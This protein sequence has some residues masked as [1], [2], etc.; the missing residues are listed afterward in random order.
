MGQLSVLEGTQW[1][2]V[3]LLALIPT[4]C[5]NLTFVWAVQRI[6]ST[7][8]AIMGALEPLTAVIVGALALGEELS[9]GQELGI[10]IVL[11]AVLLLVLSPF[12]SH[13]LKRVWSLIVDR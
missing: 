2:Y 6:G 13:C 11:I 4:V 9:A 7:P 12:I 3:F 10:V 1:L 8:S 5:S